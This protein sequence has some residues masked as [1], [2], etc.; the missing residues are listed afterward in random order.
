MSQASLADRLTEK[1][2]PAV[3]RFTSLKPV[4][5]LRSGVLAIMPFTIVG[6]IFLLLANFPISAVADFFADAGLTPWLNQA[7]SATFNMIGLI[8]AAA[9]TYA[10]VKESGYEALV[11][12]MFGL[13]TFVLMLNLTAIATESQEVVAGVIPMGWTG[14]KG[15]I[16][17]ILI[18]ELVGATYVW[19][20]K[21][22]IVIKMPDG[23]PPAVANSF[24][25]LI[26]GVAVI[27][28]ATVVWGLF[29][30]ILNST[31][32]D[33]IYDTIQ[34][35][36]QGISD[37]LG[38]A[39]VVA[40]LISFLWWFGVHGSSIV[41]GIMT[42]L[43]TANSL[44][45]QA[46]LDS[47]RALTTA[48]GGRIVTQQFLDQGITMT[49]S[50]ITIG[51]VLFMLWR[52]RSAQFKTLGKLG[53]APAVFNI[54][55]PISFGTPIVMNP[56]M[57]IPF[58]LTPIACVF[59]QYFALWSGLVPLY[60][61]ILAPWTTPPIISGFIV[62]DWRT[63]VMQL[64]IMVASVLIYLPFIR[65]VDQMAKA[66]EDA[67]HQAHLAAEAEAA[68]AELQREREHAEYAA[69]HAGNSQS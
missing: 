69:H 10:Y 43:L 41:G 8:A 28:A 67:A 37:S 26:P 57:F 61:G 50:G 55:E 66:D 12:S 18:G 29:D 9:I 52:A 25:A 54:N 30:R 36:L 21:R 35:P 56:I 19:F 47:G 27:T 32:P 2:V 14:S 42:P 22:N 20:L 68:A 23:V 39:T 58:V 6:S 51:I 48:N 65:K 5:A 44:Q 62:G 24:T 40:F 59:I 64:I 15:L 49:G 16:L 63:A 4:M 31:L 33:W 60:T 34:T 3:Q 1:V 13:S 17:A 46:I 11:P 53:G 7:Y 45:N 38:G